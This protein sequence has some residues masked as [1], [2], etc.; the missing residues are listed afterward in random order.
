MKLH[1]ANM[2]CGGCANAVTATIKQIDPQ[3]RIEV[4][5]DGR[6]VTVQSTQQALAFESA[7]IEAGFPPVLQ[8]A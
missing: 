6:N 4:D 7:L 1:I 5:L 3:A 8:P 2:N